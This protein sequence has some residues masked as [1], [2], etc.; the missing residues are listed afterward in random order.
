MKIIFAALMLVAS[1]CNAQSQAPTSAEIQLKIQEAM[2]ENLRAQ[3]ELQRSIERQRQLNQQRQPQ[4]K[5][6]PTVMT[7]FV[8]V[9]RC[10]SQGYQY[11]L[12]MKQ[13][14]Y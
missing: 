10:T 14:S 5:V 11:P 8:C 7:D 4:I 6:Q 13:C 9:S 3:L 1:V 2:N 12:C